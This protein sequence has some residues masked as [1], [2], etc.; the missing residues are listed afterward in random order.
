MK[1]PSTR[2]NIHSSDKA[3]LRNKRVTRT[4]RVASPVTQPSAASLHV[5]LKEEHHKGEGEGVKCFGPF[6]GQ[7]LISRK[8][9]LSYIFFSFVYAV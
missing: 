4:A 7:V 1:W 5:T 2:P 3:T 9:V 6:E 8:A